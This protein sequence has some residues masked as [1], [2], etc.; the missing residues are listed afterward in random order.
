VS[1]TFD[2]DWLT[3]EVHD[4]GIGGANPGVGTGLIGVADRVDAAEGALTLTSPIGG[5]TTLLVRLPARA[6]PHP[7]R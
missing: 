3:V 4:N 6:L 1:V 7:D 2:G 5:G